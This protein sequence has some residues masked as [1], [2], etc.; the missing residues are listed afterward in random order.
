MTREGFVGLTVE[1]LKT[2]AKKIVVPYKPDAEEDDDHD[3]GQS[4]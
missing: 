3:E 2:L 1:D 4:D